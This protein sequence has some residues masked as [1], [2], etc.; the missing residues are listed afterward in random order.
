MRYLLVTQFPLF[1]LSKQQSHFFLTYFLRGWGKGFCCH[2]FH[3][4]EKRK[5]TKKVTFKSMNLEGRNMLLCWKLTIVWGQLTFY[6]VYALPYL[7][8]FSMNSTLN[9]K[10]YF[11]WAINLPLRSQHKSADLLCHLLHPFFSSQGLEKMTPNLKWEGMFFI[12]G[13]RLFNTSTS[14]V[15]DLV[16]GKITILLHTHIHGGG[17]DITS[18]RGMTSWQKH[19]PDKLPRCYVF[20]LAPSSGSQLTGV[21][22]VWTGLM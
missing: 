15:I 22:W 19:M 18:F 20:H 14:V 7:N 21:T 10:N 8:F 12:K 4:Y 9:V 5:R 6:S 11:L 13:L 3:F 2:I 16:S 1:G 17:I